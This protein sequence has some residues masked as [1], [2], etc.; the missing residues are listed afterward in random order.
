MA[1]RCGVATM[2]TNF[3][4]PA[5]T[6]SPYPRP[7]GLLASQPSTSLLG[8]LLQISRWTNYPLA[9][10]KPSTASEFVSLIWARAHTLALAHS[11]MHTYAHTCT[12]W[13]HH[14][15]TQNFAAARIC[16][17]FRAWK[18]WKNLKMCQRCN[19]ACCSA[20]Q[21]VAVRCSVVQC[22]AVWCSVVQCGAVCCSVLQW[23]Q[24]DHK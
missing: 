9:I 23:E 24:L 11:H 5:P 3:P 14:M 2:P 20:L 1:R 17:C 19:W 15:H 21:C 16:V 8:Y 7:R 10:A 13:Q 4:M 22:G 18:F 12:Y 6:R